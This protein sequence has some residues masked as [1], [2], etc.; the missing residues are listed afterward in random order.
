MRSEEEILNTII[1]RAEGDDRIRAA[2]L[3]GSRA[4]ADTAQDMFQDF[5]V[6]YFVTDI[7][8]F[9]NDH[10]WIDC[11]GDRIIL[12]MPEAMEDPPPANNGR[13]PYLMQLVDGRI[14]LTLVPIAEADS[15]DDGPSVVLLDKDGLLKHQSSFADRR[16]VSVPSAKLFSD[17][18]NE[19]WWM[20]LNV[21]KGLWRKEITYAKYMFGQTHR[22]QLMKMLNWYIAAG[23]NPN[24][25]PG[26][27]GRYIERCLEPPLWELLL[28]TYSDAD[29]GHTWRSLEGMCALFRIAARR[30]SN[31][32]S[33]PYA[34][35]EDERVTARLERV[36]SLSQA[37][38]SPRI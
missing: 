13:F 7:Q 2:L 36:R 24:C 15:Y 28:S 6:A 14:D 23:S 19:F 18:C 38:A 35:V 10:R 27:F 12:Q 16:H 29:I 5:D 33:F 4:D 26:K 11:F 37:N 32:L 31:Q 34:V 3:N 25:N 30:V 9:T 17:C 21:A 22:D 8:S 20:C 1:N